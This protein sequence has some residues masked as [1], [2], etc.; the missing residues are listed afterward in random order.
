MMVVDHVIDDGKIKK[1]QAK[2]DNKAKKFKK[3]CFNVARNK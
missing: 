2:G 1:I 3:E